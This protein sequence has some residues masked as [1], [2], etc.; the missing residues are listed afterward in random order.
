M[1]L[2]AAGLDAMD[3]DNQWGRYRLRLGQG[4][5]KKHADVLRELFEAAY[6]DSGAA[7]E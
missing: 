5:V 6:R 7:K 4:D 2:E 3:Y 1:K